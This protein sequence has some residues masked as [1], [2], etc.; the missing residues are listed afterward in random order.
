MEEI[1]MVFWAVIHFSIMPVKA[2]SGVGAFFENTIRSLVLCGWLVGGF[3]IYCFAHDKEHSFNLL[4][5]MWFF[6]GGVLF[7]LSRQWYFSWNSKKPLEA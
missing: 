6:V 4:N 7:F 1:F 5:L 2:Q 3:W